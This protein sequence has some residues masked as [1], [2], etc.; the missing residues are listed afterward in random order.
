MAAQQAT[1]ANAESSESALAAEMRTLQ[2]QI[3]ALAQSVDEL[4]VNE[5]ENENEN[6]IV[7]RK[8]VVT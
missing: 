7:R 5:N 2:Q 8:A 6:E 3:A 4:K 1:S